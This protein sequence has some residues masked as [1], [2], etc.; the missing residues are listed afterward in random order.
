MLVDVRKLIQNPEAGILPEIPTL[1]RLQTLDFCRRFLG[2]TIKE[3]V[4]FHTLFEGFRRFTNGES[5]VLS[6]LTL[7]GKTQF[8]YKIIQCG[9]EILEA[10]PDQKGD[11]I[12][13]RGAIDI[14]NTPSVKLGMKLGHNEARVLLKVPR[15]LGVNR[16]AMF[17]CPTDFTSH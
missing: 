11:G 16:L 10:I 8:P 1:I 2:N 12:G 7:R 4:L 17:F 3:T 14:T 9:P 13:M 6:G 5:I 15:H